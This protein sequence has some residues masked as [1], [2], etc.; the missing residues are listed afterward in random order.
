VPDWRALTAE[1]LAGLRLPEARREEVVQ[2]L[3]EH[4]E[5]EFAALRPQL[6]KEEAQR[7]ALDLLGA[8]DTLIR[9]IRK[10]EKED[11]M[12]RTARLVLCGVVAGAVAYLLALT[13]FALVGGEFV[14]AVRVARG[15]LGTTPDPAEQGLLHLA[16]G[17]WVMWLYTILRPRYGVG[18]R[19]AALAGLSLWL[20]GA[21]AAASWTSLG[22]LPANLLVV[23]A[24]V[25]L[26]AWPLGAVIGGY[27][28]E[29]SERKPAQP[30]KAS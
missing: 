2:E 19:T 9:E 21:L 25:G 5:D 3:S 4:L 6:P 12:T 26:P 10:A 18:P 7:R 30:L 20:V 27:S 15:A 11:P 28:L 16:A 8:P 29:L 17:V 1:R 23:A 22:F 14:D 24:L 13:A